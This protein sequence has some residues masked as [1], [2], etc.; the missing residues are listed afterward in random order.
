MKKRDLY[1]IITGLAVMLLLGP[2]PD[3]RADETGLFT[4]IAPDA[5]IVLDLSGSMK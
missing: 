2:A 1:L 3:S 5:M 4:S